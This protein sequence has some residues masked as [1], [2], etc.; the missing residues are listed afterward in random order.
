[1]NTL[2]IHY[3]AQMRTTL[4]TAQSEDGT[5][6]AYSASLSIAGPSLANQEISTQTNSR[7]P[8]M[9][10]SRVFIRRIANALITRG[11]L[12]ALVKPFGN[13]LGLIH[14]KPKYLRC[15]SCGGRFKSAWALLHHLTE[16]HRMVL[17]KVE[18]EQE[19]KSVKVSLLNTFK[20]AAFFFLLSWRRDQ[21]A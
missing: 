17:F 14:F 6:I 12:I 20:T 16:F 19:P 3:L 10:R 13:V 5:G 2:E 8:V 15:I 1:M 4:T 11:D 9:V 21:R 18:E 7:V